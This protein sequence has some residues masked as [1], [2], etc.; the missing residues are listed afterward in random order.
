[1][2]I[3]ALLNDAWCEGVDQI[4]RAVVFYNCIFFAEPLAWRGDCRMRSTGGVVSSPHTHRLFKFVPRE[5]CRLD[6][7]FLCAVNQLTVL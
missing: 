5:E 3:A 7:P 6:V 2:P 1:M 4:G